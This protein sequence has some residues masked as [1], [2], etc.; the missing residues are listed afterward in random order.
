MT[1][2]AGAGHRC[3][4]RPGL[5]LGVLMLDLEHFRGADLVLAALGHALRAETWDEEAEV[6]AP[7]Y[8]GPRSTTHDAVD[9]P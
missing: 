3:S 8:R 4:R 6:P 9:P 7:C 2:Q 1:T 5:W